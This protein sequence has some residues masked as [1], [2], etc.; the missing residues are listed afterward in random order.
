MTD[1]TKFRVIAEHP[2]AEVG[3]VVYRCVYPDYGITADDQR[4]TGVEH[5]AVTF[6][7]DG[8][9]PCFTLPVDKIVVV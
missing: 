8:D 7:D 1:T 3:D 4:I 2:N 9:Y 6:N 5:V